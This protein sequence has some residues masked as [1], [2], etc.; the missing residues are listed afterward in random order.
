MALGVTKKVQQ[1][2]LMWGKLSI[3]VAVV[4]MQKQQYSRAAMQLCGTA[5]A[6]VP[7]TTAGSLQA[8]L[9]CSI[10]H[11]RVHSEYQKEYGMQNSPWCM[12]KAV[13]QQQTLI[14]QQPQVLFRGIY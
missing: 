8:C 13:C 11:Q 12:A 1:A 6:P 4:K 2:H 10:T 5:L 9:M 14:Y 7:A 3:E